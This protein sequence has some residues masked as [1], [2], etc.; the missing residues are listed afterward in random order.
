MRLRL[1][2]TR[3]E[4]ADGTTS[5]IF[6][7]DHPRTWRAGQFLHYVLPHDKA[8]ERKDDRCFTIA[9]APHETNI[10]LTTRFTNGTGSTF[11]KALQALQF[12]V[13][14][15]VGEPDGDFVI[16]Q[17][18]RES[19]FI[20]GGIGITP[21]R[22]MLVDLDY[23]KIDIK[24]TLLCS[25]RDTDIVFKRQLDGLARKHPHLKV[26]YLIGR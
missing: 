23:R 2:E 12:G 4:A 8:D 14:I 9:S 10:R 18:D 19:I 26:R 22:A 25:N 3:R 13:T 11:K 6:Y 21:F 7:P 15:E 17:P 1:I 5:F 24:A 20:A 16:D